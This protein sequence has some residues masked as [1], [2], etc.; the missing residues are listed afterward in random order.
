MAQPNQPSQQPEK[1]APRHGEQD[2]PRRRAEPGTER[3]P[4]SQPNQDPEY[5]NNPRRQPSREDQEKKS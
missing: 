4:R 3:N 1:Q 2:D 5:P